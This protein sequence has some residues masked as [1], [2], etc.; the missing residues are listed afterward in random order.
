MNIPCN[1]NNNR[2]SELKL[3]IFDYFIELDYIIEP[4][5]SDAGGRYYYR[6]RSL[7]QGNFVVMD[8]PPAYNS[9]DNFITIGNYLIENNFSAPKIFK[10]DIK[11]GFLLLEDFGDISLKYHLENTAIDQT[12]RYKTYC[13]IIDLLI[14]L[15]TKVCPE[16]LREFDHAML[17]DEVKIF[18]DWYIPYAYKRELTINEFKEFIQIWKNILC[19]LQPMQSAVVLRDYHVENII[20]LDDRESTKKLG[21]LDFQD[22]LI[23]PPVY[24]LVSVLEDARVDVARDEAL[25]LIKY[26]AR[27]KKLDINAVLLN[28]HI[29]GAQRN[30]RILGVFAR[31]FYRD[32]NNSYL[33]Y[34]PRV[35]QY[36]EYDLS[37]PALN[38]LRKWFKNLK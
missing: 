36:L 25:I 37:H 26:F 11:L 15:Q 16:F 17:C 4:M 21:L 6:V 5:V 18:V 3:F 2:L 12:K 24:D 22:A 10:Q 27:K 29:L 31:K 20:Y 1:V 35:Q 32:N 28:Y 14:D 38:K 19:N 13:S 8:C 30:C 33:Q 23:G 7:K 34:I 9:V